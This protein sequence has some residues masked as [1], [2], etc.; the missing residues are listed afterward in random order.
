MVFA[1]KLSRAMRQHPHARSLDPSDVDQLKADETGPKAPG[2]RSVLV[3]IRVRKLARIVRQGG[4][5]ALEFHI[6]LWRRGHSLILGWVGFAMRS[7]VQLNQN[8]SAR[9]GGYPGRG[10]RDALALQRTSVRSA[11]ALPL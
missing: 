3:L 5:D 6:Q 10:C 8:L 11:G 7:E 9:A 2:R 1:E 4:R